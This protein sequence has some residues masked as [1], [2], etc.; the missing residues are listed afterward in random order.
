MVR[1]LAWCL[2]KNA[3]THPLELGDRDVDGGKIDGHVWTP[4]AE[5]ADIL[6]LPGSRAPVE[7]A[8]PTDP[9]RF[10]PVYTL[11]PGRLRHPL[12]NPQAPRQTASFPRLENFSGSNKGHKEHLCT[13]SGFLPF[14]ADSRPRSFRF[15]RAEAPVPPS[16]AALLSIP[17]RPP[18]AGAQSGGRTPQ[19]REIT[20]NL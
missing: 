4:F 19:G 12:H 20:E 11:P 5:T 14:L 9:A 7:S 3:H 13:S 16:L 1:F 2:T 6:F 17:A 15:G 8:S 18:A 10:H